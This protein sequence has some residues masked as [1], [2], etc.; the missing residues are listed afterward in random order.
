MDK[1]HFSAFRGQIP[2]FLTE[3]AL[4]TLMVAV[5]ACIGMLNT[6]VLLGAACG[7]LGALLNH[8]AM[9]FALLKAEKMENVAKAQLQMRL[10]Y[11][12]RTAILFGA[13]VV[14]IKFGG[15]DPIAT[16]LP[17]VLMRISL[18]IGGFFVKGGSVK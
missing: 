9:I 16:L 4:C 8:C 13:L 15:A 18:F 12:F 10:N 11:W 5:F 7:L 14:A 2:I 1:R 6:A 3:L 17:L